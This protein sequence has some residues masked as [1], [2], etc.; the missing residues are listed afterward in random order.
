MTL[1][2]PAVQRH[3][4]GLQFAASTVADHTWRSA[5]ETYAERFAALV[6]RPQIPANL[7]AA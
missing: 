1:A 7:R 4:L 3:E 2:L 5:Y 6:G